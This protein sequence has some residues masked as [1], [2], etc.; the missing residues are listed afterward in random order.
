MSF[1]TTK[2]DD[3]TTGLLGEGRVTKYHARIEAIGTLDE[4]TAALGLARA[5]CLDSRSAPIILEAQ[6]DLYKLMAEVAATPENAEKFRS[7]D[8]SRVTWL[9][10]QTDALSEIVEMPKE[11]IVSGDSLAGAALSLA[12]AIIR[13]AERRVVELHD[14]QEVSNPELQRYLNRLSSLCFVLELL[15]N[16]AAGHRTTLAKS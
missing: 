1:Y 11:F 15:E 16:Q 2:G 7:I 6:R 3:G 12:R 4:S 8:S 13:R 5:Q 9:E 14:E 10:E